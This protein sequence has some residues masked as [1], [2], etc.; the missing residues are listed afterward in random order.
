MTS[1]VL[2]LNKR[3]VVIA[4]D[5][6]VTTSGGPHPRYSKSAT[7]I[8]ELSKS[9]NVAAAIFGSAQVDLVPWDV[10]IKLFRACLGTRSFPVVSEYLDTL[11]AFLA[12]NETLFPAA[13]RAKLVERQF[14]CAVLRVVEA[15]NS[16]DSQILDVDLPIA[17]RQS[18]WALAAGA[19]RQ[20]C[21]ADGVAA[22]LTET[23]LVAALEDLPRW[24]QRVTAELAKDPRFA[25]IDANALAELAHRL[26]Y[27]VEDHSELTRR[28]RTKLTH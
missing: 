7:K 4:A 2:I 20:K 23:A 1:E 21:K 28:D 25:A 11:V 17:D 16:I 3:A 18:K 14:D 24:T 19:L 8:F 5:S 9:G 13:L 12:R 6:A 15:A 27:S 10:A 22:P 26:R